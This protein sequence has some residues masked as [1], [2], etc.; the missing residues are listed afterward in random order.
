MNIFQ[1]TSQLQQNLRFRIHSMTHG[2]KIIF[3]TSLFAISCFAVSP[4]W[5]GD[6]DHAETTST[7]THL[8]SLSIQIGPG[9]FHIGIGVPHYSYAYGRS[10]LHVRPAPRHY[11]KHS[12]HYDRRHHHYASPQRSNNRHGWKHDGPRRN[13]RGMGG[14]GHG[15]HR[16]GHW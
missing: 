6:F 1:S 9:G 4:A 11:W 10:H 15:G 7:S 2:K 8:T 3:A 14:R 12:R 13:F 5:A 16:S